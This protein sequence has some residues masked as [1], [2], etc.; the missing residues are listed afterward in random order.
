MNKLLFLLLF[1]I[2]NNLFAQKVGLA[3]SGGGALG[4]AHIGVIKAL[5]ENNIPIDFIAGTSVGAMFGGYYAAG[6]TIRELDS[7]IKTESFK[8]SSRGDINEAF[9]YFYSDYDK[10]ASW[11]TLNFDPNSLISTIP[12]NILNPLETD[13]QVLEFYSRADAGSKG[14][15]DSLLIPFRC[16][17]ADIT[18]R[19]SVVFKSGNLGRA[20]RASF[21]YPFFLKPVVIDSNLFVDGGLYNNFPADVLDVEFNP[22]VIIGSNVSESS[23]PPNDE[24][25]YSQ[26][27]SMMTTATQFAITCESSVLIEPNVK[28]V[29]LFNFENPDDVIQKGYDAAMAKM[30][31]IKALIERRRSKNELNQMRKNFKAKM[32]EFK[33]GDVKIS[34]LTNNQSKYITRLLGDLNG[35]TFSQLKPKIYRIYSDENIKSVYPITTFNPKTNL[36]DLELILTREK[37]FTLELGGNISNK[38]INMGF[39]GIKYKRLGKNAYQ[40][41]ANTYFGKLY[42]SVQLL[43]RIDIPLKLPIYIETELTFN[44]FDY[45]KSSNNFFEDL[46]PAY[47]INRERFANIE[48]GLPVFRKGKLSGGFTVSNLLYEYYQTRDFLQTDTADNTSFFNVSYYLHYE[49]NSLNRKMYSDK[50][51]QFYLRARFVNGEQ[52]TVPGTTSLFPD[53]Y[54]DIHNWFQFK[55][56]FDKYYVIN[57]KIKIGNYFQAVAT[58]MPFMENYT[59][60][61][62]MAP[63]FNPIPESNTIFLPRFRAHSFGAVGLK[64]VFSVIKN[65]DLRVEGYYFQPY[66]EIAE[67]AQK[68]AFYG[69][70]LQKGLYMANS[71]LVFSSPIGPVALSLNYYDGEKEPFSLMFHF[72][73]IL[74]NRRAINK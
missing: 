51:S 39:A 67:D 40:W 74:F 72:G 52:Y 9:T 71:T 34:G 21:A 12:T 11:I 17:A 7:V 38:P 45:F 69:K 31:E 30:D 43:N 18:N 22:D 19:K 44:R 59:S 29:G 62:L 64:T 33:L 61:I 8:R 54:R 20:I 1:L 15:F 35:L 5:E 14:N 42:S 23:P 28:D 56:L 57:Q 55:F 41:S 25:L 2:S 68:N 73:Y 16:L 24:N 47:L 53:P 13:L 70:V 66:Q 10:N 27:R 4:L 37:Q 49:R 60:T 63:S 58:N 46:K 32:N 65:L 3:L 48:L 26:V 6:F 36:F 50:G